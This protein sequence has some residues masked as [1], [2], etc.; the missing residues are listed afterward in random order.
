MSRAKTSRPG[1]RSQAAKRRFEATKTI[2][3]AI[4]EAEAEHLAGVFAPAG[5]R[6]RVSGQV[7]VTDLAPGV[8]HKRFFA[9]RVVAA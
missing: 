2:V 4:T 3:R 9:V 6:V 5:A 7:V 8:Q 1:G